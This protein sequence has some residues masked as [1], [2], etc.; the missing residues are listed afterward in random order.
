MFL[1]IYMLCENAFLQN[2][3]QER[4]EEEEDAP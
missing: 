3:E 2:A 4:K 1:A